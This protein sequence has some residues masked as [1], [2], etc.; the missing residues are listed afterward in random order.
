[1]QGERSLP[2]VIDR[3]YDLLALERVQYPERAMAGGMQRERAAGS[4]AKIRC[5]TPHILRFA[6]NDSFG[7]VRHKSMTPPHSSQYVLSC[8]SEQGAASE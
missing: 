8:N 1:M 2:R 5:T 7:A 3:R 4:L 6:D